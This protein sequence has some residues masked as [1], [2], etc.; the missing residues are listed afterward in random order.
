MVLFCYSDWLCILEFWY[1]NGIQKKSL[2]QYK[3]KCILDF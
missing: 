1:S 3:L 2:S